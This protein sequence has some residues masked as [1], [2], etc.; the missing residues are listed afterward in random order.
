MR[1]ALQKPQHEFLAPTDGSF[2]VFS[3]DY[4]FAF[5]GW[6]YHSEYEIHLIRKSSGSFYVGTFAGNF[7]P[8]NLV[9][10]G[11]NLPH[12]WVTA[13]KEHAIPDRDVVLHFGERFAQNCLHSFSDCAPLQTLLDEA[14]SGIQFSSKPSR[15]AALLLED[16]L[17]VSHLDRLA[18]FFQLIAELAADGDRQHLSFSPPPDQS[19]MGG[20]LNGILAYIARNYS[21]SDLTC[22]SVAAAHGMTASTLSQAFERHVSRTCVEYINRLRVYKACQLL[23]ET[24]D[25]ITTICYDVGYNTLSTFNRNFLRFIGT[26]P[27]EFRIRRDLG[28]GDRSWHRGNR[29]GPE[30]GGTRLAN[31]IPRGQI[32]RRTPLI[33]DECAC[34]PFG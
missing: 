27:S 25:A 14:H 24:N 28:P 22:S 23:V 30:L 10:I 31:S 8:Y 33:G 9:M 12:M 17:R 21:N 16:L 13:P 1:A 2:E 6:H 11:P 34:R 4:P 3:H 19:K 26:T 29:S 20:R 32:A 18:L 5:S 7:E 15:Q